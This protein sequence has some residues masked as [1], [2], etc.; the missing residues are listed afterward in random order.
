MDR[1]Q[2]HAQ[3]RSETKGGEPIPVSELNEESRGRNAGQLQG[4]GVTSLGRRD[5]VTGAEVFDHPDGHPHQVGPQHPPHHA[6]PHVHAVNA[7]GEELIVT[8]PG[9]S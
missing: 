5:P 3:V 6:S 4:Q 8:Y 7:Q 1:A 9:P 2:Q